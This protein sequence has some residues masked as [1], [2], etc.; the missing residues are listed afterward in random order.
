MQHNEEL[1]EYL[2]DLKPRDEIRR[3]FE[4]HGINYR[5]LALLV[6]ALASVATILSSTIINVALPDI[7][8][9]YGIGQ[10]RAQW[11][12]SSN[13]AAATIGMLA[14]AWLVHT[15]GLRKTVFL[16]MSAFLMGCFLGGL[17]PN[18]EIMIVARVLQGIPTGVMTSLSM[19]VIFLLFPH[20]QQGLAMGMISTGIILAP[21]VG[22]AIGGYLVDDFSWRFVFYMGLPFSLLCMPAALVYLPDREKEDEVKS[23]DWAG[24]AL[25]SI[26][27]TLLLVGLSNGQREGWDSNYIITCFATAA[28][29]GAIFLSWQNRVKH[30]LLDLRVFQYVSFSAALTLAAIVGAGVYGSTYI[31][32]LFMQ[33]V[34]GLTALDSGLALIPAGITMALLAPIVGRMADLIDHRLLIG[35]GSFLIAVSFLLFSYADAQTSYWIYASIVIISRIGISAVMAPLSLAALQA[36]PTNMVQQGSAT[37]N[38]TRQLG[39]A[40]GVNLVAV[41]LQWRTSFHM[42][43]LSA[44]QS[45]DNETAGEAIGKIMQVLQSSGLTAAEQSYMAAKY[46]GQQNLL[47]ATTLGFQDTNLIVS[48]SFLLL[49]PLVFLVRSK[50]FT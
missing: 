7:M 48:L 19:S 3:K 24:L 33:L 12:S 9:A 18:I 36:I 14:S 13:L 35:T 20:R 25:A 39:G 49:L 50:M 38:F 40:F 45:I 37:F 30:P 34:Q 16:S 5:W 29:T 44:A 27:I 46:I 17:A 21:A 43:S 2:N 32:P 28:I 4:Q 47:Q 22:P 26:A 41:T 15:V 11:L 31:I 6:M 1:R 23:L 42:D 8:G 10:D